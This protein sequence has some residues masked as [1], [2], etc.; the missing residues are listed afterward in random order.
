[1]GIDRVNNK[2]LIFPFVKL[3]TPDISLF[4]TNVNKD[5]VNAITLDENIL[6][7]LNILSYTIVFLI[8]TRMMQR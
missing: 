6:T 5:S 1:M 4:Y 3:R 7:T 8:N 2:E